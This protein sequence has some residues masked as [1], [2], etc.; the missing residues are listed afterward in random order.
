MLLSKR[1]LDPEAGTV[2]GEGQEQREKIQRQE[3]RSKLPSRGQRQNSTLQC[4]TTPKDGW[5]I[6]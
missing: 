2:S 5:H 6:D 3:P 1:V 4:S